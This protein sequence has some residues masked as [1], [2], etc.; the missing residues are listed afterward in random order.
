[1]LI[2]WYNSYSIY[3][4]QKHT[5]FLSSATKLQQSNIFTDICQSFCSGGMSTLVHAGIHLLGRYTPMGRYTPWQVHTHPPPGRYTPPPRQVQPRQVQP[6]GRYIP[7]H[8]GHCSGWYASY[9]NAFLF[10]IFSCLLLVG[11]T[12]HF[13]NLPTAFGT[14]AR[15]LYNNHTV[16]QFV[17]HN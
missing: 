7:A 14:M 5:K 12:I 4:I 10:V 17:I 2:T 11:W 13:Q 15:S 9:W 8:N 1:M 16:Q 6:P 3:Y